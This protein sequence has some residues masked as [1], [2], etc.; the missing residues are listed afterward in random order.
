MTT[1]PRTG[2]TLIEMVFVIAVIGMVMTIAAKTMVVVLNTERSGRDA[3]TANSDRS[4]LA[5]D[6]RHDVNAAR[7]A[8]VSDGQD[9]AGSRLALTLPE[10]SVIEYSL[11]DDEVIRLVKQDETISARERYR[12][13]YDHARFAIEPGDREFVSLI[14]TI[15]HRPKKVSAPQR[16][17]RIDALTGK[18][19]RFQDQEGTP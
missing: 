4:R 19:L 2:K 1:S 15:T 16:Q 17:L 8:S 18:D 12:I 9:D 11:Q 7:S 14:A 3:F 6:F 13:G 10:R 5:N